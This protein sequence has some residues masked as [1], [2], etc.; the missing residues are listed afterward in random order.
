MYPIYFEEEEEQRE[1][2][3][4]SLMVEPDMVL[5]LKTLET[6]TWAKT[7]SQMLNRLPYQVPHKM[8]L[9]LNL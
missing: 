7:K 8:Y 3:R 9:V 5:D 4:E 2:E 6:R 1:S